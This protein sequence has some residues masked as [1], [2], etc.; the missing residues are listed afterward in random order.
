[1]CHAGTRFQGVRI[2]AAVDPTRADHSIAEDGRFCI[3]VHT[4]EEAGH[5]LPCERECSEFRVINMVTGETERTGPLHVGETYQHPG[6]ARLVV[7]RLAPSVAAAT[8]PAWNTAI[9][10]QRRRS[11]RLARLLQLL[12]GKGW[13]S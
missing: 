9:G 3:V 13:T 2:L 5:A 11:G 10:R 7:G 12:G 6:V 8:M 1:V 4:Q